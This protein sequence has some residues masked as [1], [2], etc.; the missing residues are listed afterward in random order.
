MI[1][2][3]PQ[4][5]RV[6]VAADDAV[7]VLLEQLVGIDARLAGLDV[8]DAHV[9]VRI[10]EGERPRPQELAGLLR[11]R[12]HAAAFGDGD[13]D[14]LLGAGRH[15]RID[16]FDES[17]V[18]AHAGAN[19]DAFLVVVGVPIVAGQF[20]EVPHQ[21]AGLDVERHGRVA[22]ELCRRCLG[23]GVVAAVAFESRVRIGIGHAPID[24]FADRIVRARQAPRAGGPLVDRHVAPGVAARLARRGRDVELPDLFACPRV[25]SGDEAELALSLLTGAV[26]DHLAIGDQQSAGGDLAV[27]DLGFPAQLAG[28]GIERQQESVRRAEVDHVLVDAE[29]LAARRRGHDAVWIVALDTP[30]S[31]RRWWRRGPGCWRPEPSRT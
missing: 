9:D 11:D 10:V 7:A 18:R 31:S 23:D 21:L 19:Q 8:D 22:I 24:D 1:G 20:L 17:R 26:R 13:D 5:A 30:K 16:P 15:R 2:D 27:V 14:V 4:A 3:L 12:K 28:P 29:A 6:V 25:V